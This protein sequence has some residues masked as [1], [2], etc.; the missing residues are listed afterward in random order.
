MP[1][2]VNVKF[3]G[4]DMSVELLRCAVG[5][6]CVQ[7][8]VLQSPLRPRVLTHAMCVAVLHHLSTRARR[9]D[10]IRQIAASVQSGGEVL[11]FVWA[12]EQSDLSKRKQMGP[13]GQQ[14]V[15]V[16][17]AIPTMTSD[18]APA[19][20]LRYYHLFK[21]GELEELVAEAVPTCM[22]IRGGYNRD[23]WFLWFKVF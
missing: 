13:P 6:E 4:M 3:I 5:Q 18:T 8:N 22:V 1:R 19:K 16:P 14:D 17:F 12:L 21:E 23:N 11:L 10:A 7:S 15:M 9:L 20:Q 2:L